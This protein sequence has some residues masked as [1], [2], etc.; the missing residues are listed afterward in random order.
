MARDLT[1]II[2]Y[3]AKSYQYRKTPEFLIFL[4]DLVAKIKRLIADLL[5]LL[6]LQMPEFS[7]N[8]HIVGNLMQVIL[9]VAGAVALLLVLYFAWR[10][11][12]QL[13]TQAL[14]A[15]RGQAE[16]EIPLDANGWRQE[17]TRLAQANQ[18]KPACRAAYISV[19]KRLDEKG[20]L[21]FNPSRTNYEYW[22]ALARHKQIAVLFRQLANVVES[23][24]FGNRTAT[25]S[26]YETCVRVLGDAERE[27]EEAHAAAAAAKANAVVR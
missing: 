10:R 25:D 12:G 1:P 20:I 4:Q 17:A 23:C 9:L 19:M 11:F 14:R 27:I 2:A 16:E 26:D 5:N 21:E 3:V 7:A 15:R 22:Y 18:Y 6:H 13:S 24:W 8:T